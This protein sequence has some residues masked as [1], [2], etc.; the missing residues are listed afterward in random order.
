MRTKKKRLFFL[1]MIAAALFFMI[2]NAHDGSGRRT[3]QL[4]DLTVNFHG[5]EGLSGFFESMAGTEDD[6]KETG[7]SG[8]MESEAAGNEAVG[9]ETP[10]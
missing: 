10:E 8:T 6:A 1:L 3:P 7:E 9:S 4:S 2:C 5:K